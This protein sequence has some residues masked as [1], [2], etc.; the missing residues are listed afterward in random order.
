MDILVSAIVDSDDPAAT[1]RQIQAKLSESDRAELYR[2][3]VS[4]LYASED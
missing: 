3:Y 1:L 4:K 2:L